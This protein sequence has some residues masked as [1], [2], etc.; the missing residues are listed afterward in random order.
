MATNK[1]KIT[2]ADNSGTV[3]VGVGDMV[4][5]G[6]G[7]GFGEV[8]VSPMV[9]ICVLLQSLSSPLKAHP[10]APAPSYQLA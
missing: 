1:G 6:D 3:G 4:L 2:K 5:V 7:V 9:T 8:G 10:L